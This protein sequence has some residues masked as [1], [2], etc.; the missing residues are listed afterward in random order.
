MGVLPHQDWMG[1][2]PSQNWM[3]VPPWSGL[4]GGTPIRLDG[5]PTLEKRAAEQAL[6]TRLAV[7]LLRSRRRTFLFI[8]MKRNTYW[9]KRIKNIDHMV[10]QIRYSGE[11][12]TIS[13]WVIRFD[14]CG[15]EATFAVT[16]QLYLH[17]V[18]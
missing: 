7:C 18:Q 6:A 17:W 9:L 11:N 16:L 12:L 8:F 10:Q 2:P 15:Y 14:S 4:D 13:F 1:Y 5:I 3:E